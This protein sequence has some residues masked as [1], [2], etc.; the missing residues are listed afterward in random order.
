ML[1]VCLLC[2]AR[3]RSYSFV[4][5]PSPELVDEWNRRRPVVA[6]WFQN[7]AITLINTGNGGQRSV[8]SDP[9]GRFAFDAV[10]P[11]TYRLWQS[12]LRIR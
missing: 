8:M 10:A 9:Q 5:P 12:P 1:L 4:L 11:G 2:D 7:V 3:L 6:P